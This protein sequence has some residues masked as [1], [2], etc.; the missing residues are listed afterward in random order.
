MLAFNM[1][2]GALGG[3]TLGAITDHYANKGAKKFADKQA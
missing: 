3:L 1:V 2:V